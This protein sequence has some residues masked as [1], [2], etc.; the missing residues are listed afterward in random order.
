VAGKLRLF[1]YRD[2]TLVSQFLEQLEGGVYDEE[3][4]RTQTART[5]S[6]KG[7]LSAHYVSAGASRDRSSSEESELSLRQ[8]GASRFSRFHQLA[9]DSSDIQTL[10]AMDEGIWD[11][12]ES[13]ELIEA[14]VVLEVPE[15]LKALEFV[16]QASALIP[17]M[18]IFAS[19]E[20]DDG[21]PLVDPEEMKTIK[22]QLPVAEQAVAI[23][24]EAPVPVLSN[25]ASDPKFKF[26]MRLKRDKIV[27]ENLED[28]DG[29]A[30][31][32][33]SI[34]SKVERRKPTQ[35]GQ[36]VRGL[37]SQNREQRRRSGGTDNGTINL[38]YP[39]AIVTPVAIFR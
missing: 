37:P 32:I 22:R 12:V 25:L 39:A 20:G 36:L 4:I 34:Q 33:A 5:G 2:D 9:T 6:L 28:L 29:E 23:T 3:S 19:F 35:V 15:F 10:D 13:G 11:Q 38:R 17:F 8:T 30:R 24:E 16:G 1:L 27:A 18:D 31:L 26:F 21:K 7:G 14:Q